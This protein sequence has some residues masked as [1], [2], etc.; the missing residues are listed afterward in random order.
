MDFLVAVTGM[1]CF[2]A[3]SMASSRPLMSHSRHGATTAS[4]GL[5]AKNVSSNRTYPHAMF[6]PHWETLVPSLASVIMNNGGLA[7]AT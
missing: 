1:L 3:Y 7:E 4:F 5:S 2:F 6:A